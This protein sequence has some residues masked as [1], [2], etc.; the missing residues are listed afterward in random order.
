M[1]NLRI[2]FSPRNEIHKAASEIPNP[3]IGCTTAGEID[4]GLKRGTIC[5]ELDSM[6]FDTEVIK[7]ERTDLPIIYSEQ[8]I[9]A[10]KSIEQKKKNLICLVLNDGLSSSEE[11]VQS[12]LNNILPEKWEIVGGS[13]GDDLNMQ[14]TY[15][16]INDEVFKGAVIVLIGTDLNYYINKENIY[17]IDK[18]SRSKVAIVTKSDE[19]TLYELDNMSASKRYAQLLGCKENEIQDYTF[20]SPFG[21]FSEGQ[22]M[23]CSCK[24]ANK[25]G[26]LSLYKSVVPSTVLWV[27]NLLDY[28]KIMENTVDEILKRGKPLFTLTFNCILRDLLYKS[29]NSEDFVNSQFAK[30]KSFGFIC[31]G[32][33]YKGLQINQTM[34]TLTFFKE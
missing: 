2:V 21:T 4:N 29:D 3:K 30:M 27:L 15:S 32:E 11:R 26:S 12:L 24:T 17:G 13:S 6:H 28:K 8:I 23:I 19:R 14:E 10:A 34:V 9:N 16:C 33:Q 20:N 7:M 31:Y 18:T 1:D 5:M 22:V 25:D